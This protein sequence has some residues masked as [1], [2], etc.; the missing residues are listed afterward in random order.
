MNNFRKLIFLNS[1]YCT[2]YIDKKTTVIAGILRSI[3][4][5]FAVKLPDIKIDEINKVYRKLTTILNSIVACELLLYVYLFIFPYFTKL[6]QLP[7]FITILCLAAIPLLILYLTYI[8]INTLFENYL[9]KY[10]GS[11]QKIKFQPNIYNI[12]PEAYKKYCETPRKSIYIVGLLIFIF[13]YYL[14]TPIFIETLI[15][16]KNFKLGIKFANLYSKI[17]PINPEIYEQRAIAKFN[18]KDYKGAVIDFELA[19]KYSLSNVF[20]NDILEAKT[21]YLSYNDMISEFEKA[22][23]V[24]KDK[25]LTGVI[26]AKKADYLM[27][28]KKYSEALKI[29]DELISIHKHGEEIGFSLENAYFNRGKAKQILNINNANIDIEIAKRMCP[30]CNF[31]N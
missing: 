7:Y 2:Y 8:V 1:Q 12:E 25:I 15:A 11:F 17:I 22:L 18:V 16:H 9:E 27:K 30:T 4:Y 24:Q 29:Y 10:I 14:L 6:M 31:E 5:K 26:K 20:D 23:S 21:Y 13:C 28:N 19:N 3:G